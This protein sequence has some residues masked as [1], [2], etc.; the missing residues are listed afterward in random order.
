MSDTFSISQLAKEFDMTTRAIRFYEDQGLLS[1]ERVGRT[2]VFSVRDRARLRL[3]QRG[4]RLGFSLQE[5]GEIL[6][7]YDDSR[8][9][10]SGQLSYFLERIQ[11]R[12]VALSQQ[13]DDIEKTLDDLKVIESQC[14]ERLNGLQADQASISDRI[15]AVSGG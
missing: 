8:I 4:K 12:R 14:H 9:G 6:D 2:R 13:V 11:E 7:M 5:I 3:I 15:R 1:P 10:E